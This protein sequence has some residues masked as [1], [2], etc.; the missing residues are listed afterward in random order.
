MKRLY[1]M[2]H[3]KSDWDGAFSSDHE[4]R[5]APRGRRA[6]QTVGRF[7]SSV[8]APQAVVTSS[9]VRAR[10]TVEIAAKAGGWECG[11]EVTDALYGCSPEA[12][13]GVSRTADD[14][15]ERLLLAGHE[16]AW[17]ETAGRLVGAASIRMVTAAV[18]CI[19]LPIVSWNEIRFGVGTIKWVVTP[20][21][22]QRF[23]G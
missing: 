6:A 12:L 20:K 3:A 10:T 1:L 18:A 5:L 15:V 23:G 11:V 7:L 8:G 4:R 13:L 21:L 17:S 22:L 2:R 14:A 9:A 19:D 16:P